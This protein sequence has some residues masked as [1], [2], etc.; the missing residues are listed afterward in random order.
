MASTSVHLPADVLARLD[1]MARR[2]R[3]SR[4]SLIV[5]AC[6]RLLAEDT[7]DWPEGF[8]EN[9]HLSKAEL[10]ELNE[11]AQEMRESIEEGRRSRAAEPF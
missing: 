11:G 6:E 10:R 5:R 2:A 9:A 8:F 4:N 7:G 1:R 3:V